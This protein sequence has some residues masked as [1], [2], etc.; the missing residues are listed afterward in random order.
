MGS[1]LVEGLLNN[2][3]RPPV[4]SRDRRE[5]YPRRALPHFNE[6]DE[7][8]GFDAL[9]TNRIWTRLGYDPETT[10]HDVRYGEDYNGEFVWV[11]AVS[12]GV[13][14]KHL[15]CGN[16]GLVSAHQPPTYFR[17]GRGAIKLISMPG[18]VVLIKSF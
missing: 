5:L 14:P 4:F 18:E 17:L 13:P 16:S 2:S 6:V 12:G 7:C 10:L 8:G 15:I 1:D 9:L 11:L 3:E